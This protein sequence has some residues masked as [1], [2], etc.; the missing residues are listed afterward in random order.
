V[1]FEVRS[2]EG[3]VGFG[4]RVQPGASREGVVGVYGEALKIALMAPAVDGRANEALVRYLAEVLGVPRLSV[5]IASGH[6]SR[7]KVVRVVGI[8]ADEAAAKLMP[9]RTA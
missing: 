7:S 8:T 4:V 1:T 5:E 6:A 9:I 3:G 2:V